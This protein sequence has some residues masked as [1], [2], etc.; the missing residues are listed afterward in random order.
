MRHSAPQLLNNI[1][2]FLRCRVYCGGITRNLYLWF[3][4]KATR[5][6]GQPPVPRHVFEDRTGKRFRVILAMLTVL[7]LLVFGFAAEFSYRVYSLKPAQLASAVFDPALRPGAPVLPPPQSLS[8]VI[9]P[10]GYTDCGQGLLDF[11][12][13]QAALAGYLPFGDETALSALRAHC[14]DLGVVYYQAF[15]FGAEDG[16]LRALGEAGAGFPLPE[17]NTGF[18]ARNRPFGFPALAPE[19]GTSAKV[20]ADIFTAPEASQRFLADLR[21]LDLTGVDGGI[22]IDLS[23]YPD[24][25]ATDLLPLFGALQSW[26]GPMGLK[27]CLIGGIEA[28]FWNNP[29]LVERVD[30]PVLL[31]FQTTSNPATPIASQAWFEAASTKAR[32]LIRPEKLSVA[33]GSFSTLWKSGQRR[34]EIIPYA[35]AMLRTRFFAGSIGFSSQSGNSQARYL[36]ENRQLNQIWVLDAASYYNQ[37]QVLGPAAQIALWPLGYE[38][39]AIWALAGTEGASLSAINAEID[40]SDHISVEGSGPFSSHIARAVSGQR[41]V[42]IAPESGLIDQLSYQQIPS[43][44]RIRLFGKAG[45]L[46]LTLAFYGVGNARQSDILLAELK[47]RQIN[48]T[49]FLS[50]NDL[51]LSGAIVEKLI[52]GGHRIGAQITPRA[53]NSLFGG[54]FSTLQNNLTQQLLQDKFGHHALLLENPSRYGQFPGDRAVL[55]QLQDLQSAGYLAVYSNLAAPYGRI[56]PEDFVQQVRRTALSSSAN[57]LGFD[58]S[59]Q[60]D[61]AVNAALPAI[62][63]PLGQDGFTFSGLPEIAG[64]TALQAFPPASKKPALRDRIIYALMAVTWIGVQNF[65]FLLALIVA[66]RSPIYLFLAFMRREKY[67]FDPAYHPAVTIIIPA[68]NEAK[69]IDKTMQSVLASDYPALKVIVVD[70]GS[71]DHTA[72]MVA[73]Y[74]KADPRVA[75]IEQSNHGKWF[76]EDTALGFVDTPIFVIV[77]ADTLLHK[78]AIKYLVQP[79]CDAKIGA[80]AGTVEIG[81]R[82]NLITASQI[83]EY[84]ISQSVMRRAYEVFN[85]ILVVPGAIGAWRTE[86]VL[87]SGLVSGDTITEDADLTVAI[88]RSGFKVVYAPKALSYTEAPNSVSAFMQQRLRWSLGMLQVAWKHRGA[89]AEGRAVGFVSILDAVWYRIISSLIYPLVDLIIFGTIISWGY[90]IATQGSMGLSDLSLSVILL[91]I[92]LTFIDVINLV[93]AF[94]FERKMEWKLLFLVPFLRFGYRQ[95][96]YI[97]SI[98]SIMHAISGRLRGWQKLKRTDTAHM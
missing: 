17:F 58:F 71:S 47:R 79:F 9:K 39:P 87:A 15:G 81:N 36:D 31:G 82:D 32:S 54:A 48:A 83:I 61:Q 22:C 59:Q 84:K 2:V 98:R 80:V 37:R 7:G 24:L 76:A 11:D 67:P 30:Q 50:T 28:G 26:L 93:A 14:R 63:E 73:Q 92:L 86:A 6:I 46:E 72:E 38:D 51:L 5:E 66:L 12:S 56:E 69:V 44:R 97:S 10:S 43:P 25:P 8:V 53:S 55:D 27:S 21:A 19:I 35:Q 62:L 77:D 74:A 3:S 78:D 52:A 89:I 85:G 49:F 65:V 33:L 45:D 96:L 68:Y 18:I 64:I 42:S 20:I 57:V 40:L 88:H 29:A 1:S 4:M 95:M 91:F 41:A 90:R 23:A 75:L 16:S 60:N 70:D 34:P 13:G 94:W